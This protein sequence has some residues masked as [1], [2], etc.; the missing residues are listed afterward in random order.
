MDADLC[1]CSGNVVFPG[2][3]VK[4][5]DLVINAGKI[6]AICVDSSVVNAAKV[7]D[8]EGLYIFPGVIDPHMHLGIY[9]DL[10]A[11]FAEQTPA[12][13]LGGVTTIVNYYRGRDSYHCYVPELIRCGEENSYID[14]TFSLGVLTRRHLAELQ[15]IAET[16]GITSYK[17]YRNYQDNIGRIFQADD[18]LTLDSADLLDILKRFR[19]LSPHMQL[20]VHCEDMDVQRSVVQALRT[21][22]AED[23]LEFFSRTSPDYVETNSIMQLMYLNKQAGGRAYAVHVSAGTSVEAIKKLKDWVGG[24]TVFE[25]CPHY[26]ALHEKSPCG[27]LAVVNP[28]I[29]TEADAEALWQGIAAGYITTIGSDNCPNSLERKFAKGHGVWEVTPGFC[30]SGMILP[31]LLSEGYHKRGLSL[32]T[33]ANVSSRNVAAA[34]DLPDKGN[35]ELGCDA[36][37]AIVDLDKEM[38]VDDDTM[39][40]CGYSVYKG[41][42]LKG[43][44][45]Y[46][47]SRGEVLQENGAVNPRRGHGSFVK[48]SL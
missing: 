33:I 10:A 19:V 24:G 26:L 27:L 12:A 37:F 38:L 11:D 9:N 45:V 48:R 21:G 36:D 39:P 4:K 2:Q 25:T 15:S 7:I 5:A 30:G 41:L 32:E 46:T 20:C 44:P 13:A 16:F 31:I 18:P 8:A 22:P 3:G 47:I 23:T 14:F 40:N 42:K 28:P 17:F 34:F 43:W 6:A 29:H 1:I 35:I